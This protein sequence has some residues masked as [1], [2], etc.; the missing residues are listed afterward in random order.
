MLYCVVI[1]ISMFVHLKIILLYSSVWNLEVFLFIYLL[2]SLLNLFIYLIYLPIFSE[3]L[4]GD[5]CLPRAPWVPRISWASWL[6]SSSGRRMPRMPG[7]HTM[8]Y[9]RCSHR[10]LRPSELNNIEK[11]IEASKHRSIEALNVESRK[12]S[13][14]QSCTATRRTTAYVTLFKKVLISTL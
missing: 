6:A 7:N 12:L 14:S 3:N 5:K 4:C 10:S 2:I 13:C 8:R 11:Q 1:S 9:Q